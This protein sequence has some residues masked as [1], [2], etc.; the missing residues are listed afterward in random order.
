MM[1]RQGLGTFREDGGPTGVRM[2]GGSNG[3]RRGTGLGGACTGRNPG[4]GSTGTG[5][6]GSLHGYWFRRSARLA[7]GGRLSPWPST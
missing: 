1:S 4:G 5:L 7:L 3:A 2:R 6:G